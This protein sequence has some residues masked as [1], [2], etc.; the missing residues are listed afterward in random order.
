MVWYA[1]AF[2]VFLWWFFTAAILVAVSQADRIGGEAHRRTVFSALPLLLLGAL[3]V[4]W[5]VGR[6]DPAGAFV[7]FT[8]ALTIWG[9]FELA[10]LSGVLTGPNQAPARAWE[11]GWL[12]FLRAWSA[13]AWHEIA[14]VLT[15]AIL[16][17]RADGTAV[18]AAWTFAILFAAR[19][20]AKLNV[21]FGVPNIN[22]DFLPT[23]VK[24]LAT[25]FARAPMNAF[26]PFGM[27]ALTLAFA[28]WT[29]RLI[30]VEPGTGAEVGL[31]L[32]TTLTGLAILE[33]WFLI[34]PLPDA[35]LWRWLLPKKRSKLPINAAAAAASHKD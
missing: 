11:R 33:H 18:I 26:F 10:F 19:I 12:R 8:A 7:A 30:A 31:A 28:Y 29:A 34:V 32:L 21:F 15:L 5:S 1:A 14:L 9:W 16:V 13:I 4:E 35:A 27:T 6:T 17:L 22:E 25:Y 3:G 24:Y 23:P 2:A 20:S